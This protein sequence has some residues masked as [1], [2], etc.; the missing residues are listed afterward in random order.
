MP[1]AIIISK[2]DIKEYGLEKAYIIAFLHFNIQM[3]IGLKTE[4]HIGKIWLTD[5]NLEKVD[6]EFWKLSKTKRLL[7]ELKNK[8]KVINYKTEQEPC[9]DSYWASE[10]EKVKY[11]KTSKAYWFI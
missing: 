3:Y 1:N 8:D 9:D 2:S 4:E 7:R 6:F 5:R 10:M 11:D